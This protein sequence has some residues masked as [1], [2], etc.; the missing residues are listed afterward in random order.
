MNILNRNT[1]KTRSVAGRRRFVTTLEALDQRCLL[2]AGA[3][4]AQT[5]LVSDIKGLAPHL[6]P[7][8]QNPWG[9]SETP[10]GQFRV[11]DNA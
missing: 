6:D 9:F 8:L 3:A 2:D 10:D 5:A 1:R 7:N 4:Y 11:S